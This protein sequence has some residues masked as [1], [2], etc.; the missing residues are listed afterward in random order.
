MCPAD[1]SLAVPSP[2]E[3]HVPEKASFQNLPLQLQIEVLLH[4]HW[5]EVLRVRRVR[6]NPFTSGLDGLK[7]GQHRPVNHG[8]VQ[9]K[10]AKFGQAS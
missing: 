9:P 10:P 5:R 4:L 8:T 1:V 3:L 2:P 6:S 7:P